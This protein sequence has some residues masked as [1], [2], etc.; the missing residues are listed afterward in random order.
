MLTARKPYAVKRG[1]YALGPVL[2]DDDVAAATWSELDE[3]EQRAV[4]LWAGRSISIKTR[5]DRLQRV[6]L[7][8]RQG[9]EQVR[10]RL[11]PAS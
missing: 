4:A 7:D 2:A 10:A 3:P 6:F 8:L 9:T 5:R 11:P 1:L